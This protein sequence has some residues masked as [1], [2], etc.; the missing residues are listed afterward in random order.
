MKFLQNS[1][2]LFKYIFRS[3]WEFKLPKK[4][5][6][7]LVDGIYNPFVKYINKKNFSI[8]HRRG[9]K[10][11]IIVLFKCIFNFK[12]ST[13]DYIA[14]YVK[15]V[16]PKLILTA[17]D[18][19]TIFY[20]ISKKT[21][22]KTI[23]LQKGKRGENESFIK[24]QKIFFPI[25]CKR[26]YFVDYIFVYNDTVKNF[27]KKRI[28]GKIFTIGSFENNFSKSL[29]TNQKKN[30]V[31]FI[32]NYSLINEDKSEN[33]NIVARE[34]YKLCKKNKLKFN[35]L[36]RY[37]KDPENFKKEKKFY[38]EVVDK[39][40]NFILHKTATS[41]NLLLKYKYIFATYS[42]LAAELLAKGY[43]VGFIMYKSKKNSMLQYRFGNF[44][45]LPENG[46]FWLNLKKLDNYKIEKMFNFITQTSH[47]EWY[48]KTNYLTKK[49]INFDYQNKTFQGVLKNII[50]IKNEK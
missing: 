28:S 2:I 31:T 47:K 8:L 38:E 48:L 44:E 22:I 9:E 11:N 17:F 42:T 27:Y 6:Y 18:Y 25:G 7:L 30:E 33:E 37:R 41:Y 36:P 10:L 49:V 32:S 35:I 20:K 43:K 46:L 13:L 4:N 14:E 45:K 1:N 40:L 24:N 50:S 21:G 26:K 16:S 19:H 34:L 39:N 12:F 23:M 15:I 5:K 29:T 3:K